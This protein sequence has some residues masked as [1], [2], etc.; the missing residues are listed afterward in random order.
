MA[1]VDYTP[2]VWIGN[3]QL[4]YPL[5]WKNKPIA[6]VKIGSDT[7]TLSGDMV[8]L[9]G[10]IAAGAH[11]PTEATL[12]YS[13]ESA[14]T[15]RALDVM[16]KSGQQYSADFEGNGRHYTLIF[17]A[18]NGLTEP[19]NAAFGDL[20]VYAQLEGWDTDIWDGEINVIILSGLN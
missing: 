15:I 9:R 14:A 6:S 4:R 5:R 16:W 8:F 1:G 10:K 17:A 20:A 2:N 7:R 13:W 12:T 19:K 18:D 3:T 11:L